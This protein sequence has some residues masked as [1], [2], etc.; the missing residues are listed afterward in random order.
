MDLWIDYETYYDDNY[1]LKKMTRTAYLNDPRFKVHGASVALN[2]ESPIWIRG[3]EL[4]D[5][6]R[7]VGPHVTSMFCHNGLFD[8]GITAKFYMAVRKFLGDT[9]SMAQVSVMRKYPGLR[10]SLDALAMHYF[11]DDPTMHKMHGVLEN[12]KG[13]VNLTDAQHRTMGGYA[14]QDNHVMRELFKRLLRED[15]PWHTVLQDIDLT[16]AMGVFPAMEMNTDLAAAIYAKELKAKE[17]AVIEMNIDRAQLRSNNKFAE[18]LLI[19]GLPPEE[20]PLKR[21]K[22]GDLAFAF[23]AKDA[24]FIALGEHENEKVRIL[25]ELRTGEKSAQVMNRSF[26]FS[27]LP[28]PVPVPLVVCAAHTGRH[29][30]TEFNL[31]NLKRGSDLRRCIRAANG[32]K[33]VVGD[34]KQIELRGNAWFCGEDTLIDMWAVDPNYDV[35]CEIATLIFGRPITKAEEME[36]FIGKTSELACQYGA[37]EERIAGALETADP[38]KGHQRIPKEEAQRLAPIIK[39]AYR[40]KRRKIVGMWK[41]LNDVAIPAMAGHTFPVEHK[42]VRFEHGRARLPSGR[43]LHYPELHVNEAGDWV[44]KF[45]DKKGGRNVVY[46]KKIYGGALLENLI[47]AMCYDIFMHQLRIANSIGYIPRMAVHD[48]GVFM[49]PTE[50]VELAKHSLGQIYQMAPDWFQ[51]VPILGEFGVGDTYLEAK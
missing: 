22:K 15:V 11:P 14:N 44:Y 8:H 12:F 4:P 49:V 27:Q 50:G 25:Y 31:Q 18:L 46:W 26:V 42:G 47:Q 17:E 41:W 30:G 37:G 38:P 43:S 23:A 13:V 10:V 16:L 33:L 36:R 9:M 29:G 48:E 24:N 32:H 51:G 40:S 6:W 35:Y 39:K 3:N 1:S 7:D 19:H 45:V 21:N 20:M 34:A 2:D 28:S 5:F